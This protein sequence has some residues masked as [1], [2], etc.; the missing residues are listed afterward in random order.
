MSSDTAHCQSTWGEAGATLEGLAAFRNSRACLQPLETVLALAAVPWRKLL[1]SDH[2]T[3][4]QRGQ[5]CV[6]AQC[7]IGDPSG[8]LAIGCFVGISASVMSRQEE[9]CNSFKSLTGDWC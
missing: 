5:E 2:L 8:E 4:L 6:C 7:A 3:Q 1:C 9:S